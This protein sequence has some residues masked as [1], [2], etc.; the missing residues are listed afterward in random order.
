MNGM[1]INNNIIQLSI[2]KSGLW[3]RFGK[4]PGNGFSI[5]RSQLLFSERYGYTKI[6]K[7]PFGWKFKFLKRRK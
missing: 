4:S 3:V 5:N 1:L 2:Y 6:Y 7:L